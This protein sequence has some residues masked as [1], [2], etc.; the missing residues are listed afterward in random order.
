VPVDGEITEG[1]SAIDE[2][3]VTG[4][5]MPVTKGVGEKV[6]GGTINQSGGFVMR[7]GKVGRDTVLARIV[8]MV[9]QAQRS[10]A[11]I[12]RLA[13]QVSSWFVWSAS[14]WNSPVG[15]VAGR[16]ILTGKR[17]TPGSGS[18][19]RQPADRSRNEYCA[20]CTERLC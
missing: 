14:S 13:D 4:E 2:S 6:V 10:R 17:L 18:P 16:A 11:P 9:A 20:T 3:M 15:W 12:Q 8:Q 1:R 19:I 5:S 7:T